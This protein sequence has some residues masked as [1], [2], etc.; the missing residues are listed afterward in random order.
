MS[1][2]LGR[3][4]TK[5]IIEAAISRMQD[6]VLKRCTENCRQHRIEFRQ[7]LSVLRDAQTAT[8]QK[9]EKL[10]VILTHNAEKEDA[11]NTLLEKAIEQLARFYR[12]NGTEKGLN[13]RVLLLEKNME[14]LQQLLG[15][16]RSA[17]RRALIQAL[18]VILTW[19]GFLVYWVIVN[20]GGSG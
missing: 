4:E 17:L 1:E 19:V 20:H 8:D 9:N 11:R 10:M 3:E 15:D 18:P 2:P 7:T 5:V 13:V 14:A 16:T 6:E 12:G